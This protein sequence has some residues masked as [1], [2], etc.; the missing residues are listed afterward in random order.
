MRSPAAAPSPASRWLPSR[1]PQTVQ[2][3]LNEDRQHPAT[4]A[5]VAV[6]RIDT[7]ERQRL[8]PVAPCPSQCTSSNTTART[9]ATNAGGPGERATG[10]HEAE[11]TEYGVFSQREQHRRPQQPERHANI[12]ARKH[13]GPSAASA[14]ERS[15]PRPCARADGR[16]HHTGGPLAACVHGGHGAQPQHRAIVRRSADALLAPFIRSAFFQRGAITQQCFRCIGLDDAHTIAVQAPPDLVRLAHR[17]G[18]AAVAGD[19]AF[20]Q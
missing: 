4:P 9:R 14:G 3:A 15:Q 16:V 19:E 6:L 11:A 2:A 7:A 12:P 1:T 8:T 20:P 13:R 17:I 18:I 5:R 10:E